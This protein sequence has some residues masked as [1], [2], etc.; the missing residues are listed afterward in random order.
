ML[1]KLTSLVRLLRDESPLYRTWRHRSSFP[2]LT[3]H[4]S[5]VLDVQGTFHYRSGCSIDERARLHVGNSGTLQLG[6][7]CYVGRDA[8]LAVTTGTLALGT[9]T[10]IQNRCVLLGDISIGSYCSFAP[11]VYIS[12]GHHH[13]A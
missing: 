7:N 8:E 11:N 6:C 10:S 3:V 4:H 13:F 2:G 1:H 5:A 12:S 9:E